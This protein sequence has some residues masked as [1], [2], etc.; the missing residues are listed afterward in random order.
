MASNFITYSESIQ[1]EDATTVLEKDDLDV[2]SYTLNNNPED[3]IE[4]L[5]REI[6]ILKKK[7]CT[8]KN[9]LFSLISSYPKAFERF[10]AKP[11]NILANQAK[12][13]YCEK[14]T[15]VNFSLEFKWAGQGFT[16]LCNPK[17]ELT[18]KPYILYLIY[19]MFCF[20]VID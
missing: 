19:H 12:E 2:E 18:N 14:N 7:N 1:N 3:K 6:E 20:E 11:F 10:H 5:C 15:L 9:A 16:H 17:E 13:T 8:L 4:R